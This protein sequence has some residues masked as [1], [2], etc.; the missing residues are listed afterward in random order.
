[1]RAAG[2]TDSQARLMWEK[3]GAEQSE[4]LCLSKKKLVT[5]TGGFRGWGYRKQSFLSIFFGTSS[6]LS[7]MHIFPSQKITLKIYVLAGVAQWIERWPANQGVAGSMP[8]RDTCLGCRP[9]AQ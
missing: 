2:R 8:S 7:Y 5:G 6:T 4:L 9:G 1:M 3:R